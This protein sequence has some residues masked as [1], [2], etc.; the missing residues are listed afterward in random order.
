MTKSCNAFAG[1][2]GPRYS[3][4]E[5]A[6]M[7]QKV[8]GCALL[9]F[10]FLLLHSLQVMVYYTSVLQSTVKLLAARSNQ[11]SKKSTRQA[12][13]AMPDSHSDVESTVDNRTCAD[14][15]LRHTYKIKTQIGK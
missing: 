13:A 14:L 4:A 9:Q 3:Q 2:L 8:A 5:G 6:A 12:K 10:L 7:L 11:Q 15:D 1:K